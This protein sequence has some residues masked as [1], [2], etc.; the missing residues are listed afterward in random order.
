MGF[1]FYFFMKVIFGGVE[2]CKIIRKFVETKNAFGL[3]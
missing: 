2:L 3:R 1:F